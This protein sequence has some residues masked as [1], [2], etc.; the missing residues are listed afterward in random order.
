MFN[1][2]LSGNIVAKIAVLVALQLQAL[3]L[4]LDLR[5]LVSQLGQTQ[6]LSLFASGP[7]IDPWSVGHTSVDGQVV[8]EA[9]VADFLVVRHVLINHLPG[10]HPILLEVIVLGFE[11]VQHGKHPLDVG[12]LL[13]DFSGGGAK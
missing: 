1:Y 2:C 4:L 11:G 3:D 6:L 13:L 8:E 7:Q 5:L 10:T 12:R 9:V